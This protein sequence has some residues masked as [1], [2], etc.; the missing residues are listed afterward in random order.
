MDME[1]SHL[2][3]LLGLIVAL[4]QTFCLAQTQ[5]AIR[6]AR[7]F[8]RANTPGYVLMAVGTV[9]FLNN[10]R[11]ES[12]AD[13]ETYKNM[14]LYGFAGLGIAACYYV[15]DFISIRGLSVVLLLLGKCIVDTARHAESPWRLVLI[16]WAYLMVVAG[17]WLAISPWRLRD[18]IDWVTA[19]A[20]R[21]RKL[22]AVRMAFGLLVL[23]LGLAV[24]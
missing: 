8:P 3:I 16:V 22:A 1:L 19:D 23:G 14:M 7:A 17:M 6:W 15:R 13:F 12:I 21:F 4:P 10:L 9:W 11:Q 18:L 2:A 24:F 5:T 20:G